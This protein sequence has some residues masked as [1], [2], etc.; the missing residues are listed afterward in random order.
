MFSVS[1]RAGA[2]KGRHGILSDV[3]KHKSSESL[4]EYLDGICTCK[5]EIV[6]HVRKATAILLASFHLCR[7][8]THIIASVIVGE[9][10]K[11]IFRTEKCLHRRLPRRRLGDRRNVVPVQ[12]PSESASHLLFSLLHTILYE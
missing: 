12:F 4:A 7:F 5:E 1:L 8:S 6:K 11:R 10:I 2:Q 3:R 9:N